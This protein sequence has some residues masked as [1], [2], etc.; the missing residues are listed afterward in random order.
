[1]QRYWLALD[2][3]KFTGEASAEHHPNCTGQTA[4]SFENPANE[5]MVGHVSE[6]HLYTF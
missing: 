5:W 2:K 1:M 6:K 4:Y 3:C